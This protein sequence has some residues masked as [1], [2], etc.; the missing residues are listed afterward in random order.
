MNTTRRG[1]KF[2]AAAAAGALVLAAC[3]SDDD[4]GDADDG[5]AEDDASDSAS[6]SASEPADDDAMDDDTMEE[7]GDDASASDSG[8]SSEPAEDDAME[9]GAGGGTLIWAHEQ[10]PPDLHLDDP[11]NNLSI[12]SWIRSA[13]IEGLYGISGATEYYP[14]LLDGEAELVEN[15]DGSVTANYVLRE[16][17]TWNDGTPLTTA[18]VEFTFNAIMATDGEDEE[19]NPAFV[20]LLGDRTGLDTITDFT[21]NSPTEFSVTWSSFFAGWKGVLSE[22]Y[23]AH[24]FSDDPVTA[25]GELNEALREFTLADG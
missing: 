24:N 6:A 13:M 4:A 17:L 11:N 1:Q 10:E 5:A 14:E 16:G 7:D 8:S 12:T 2:I 19:G 15:E 3:G 23:P 25:A 21:V 9:E 18:D 20:Y 22:V